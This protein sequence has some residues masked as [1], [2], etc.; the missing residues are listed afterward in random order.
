MEFLSN[1][2]N[3]IKSTLQGTTG[4]TVAPA[5][6]VEGAPGAPAIGDASNPMSYDGARRRRKQKKTKKGGRKSRRVTRRR[7]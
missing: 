1:L 3:K 7:V 6:P 4:Q 5:V 2:G